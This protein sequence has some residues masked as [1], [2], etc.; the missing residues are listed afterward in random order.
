MSPRE[1]SPSVWSGPPFQWAALNIFVKALG[2]RAMSAGR[3]GLFA[4]VA[5]ATAAKA[6]GPSS[7]PGLHVMTDTVRREIIVELSPLNLPAHASH[8]DIKQPPPLAMVVPVSGWIEGYS[9]EMVDSAGRPISQQVLH[10]LN[11][12]VPARRELFSTIMQRLGAAGAETPPVMLPQPFGHAIIGYPVQRGDTV[13]IAAMLGNPTEM[14]YPGA[15][16]RARLKYWPADAWWS[17][18]AI[19]PFYLDVMPP[20]GPHGYDLPPGHSS[21]SWEG[22]PAI[23]GRILEIGGHLHKY[24]VEIRLEDVTAGRVIWRAVP[25]VDA[26]GEVTDIPSTGYWWRFGVPLRPDHVYR[27]T[28]VYDNP[29]GQWI[30]DGAMG[31]L[32]GV[33]LPDKMATWPAVDRTTAEYQRDVQSTNQGGMNMDDMDM[34]EMHQMPATPSAHRQHRTSMRDANSATDHPTRWVRG[35]LTTSTST[36]RVAPIQ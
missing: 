34:H 26:T 30:P 5:W 10:H 32:G 33:F 11:F 31:A 27:A 16:M 4:L 29:T 20:A 23:A 7:H 19:S 28:A 3:S 25:A 15:R 2:L 13:L 14:S 6:Q 35:S 18:L 24:G 1:A 9:G 22:S 8:M 21:K 36:R 17:P 12:I